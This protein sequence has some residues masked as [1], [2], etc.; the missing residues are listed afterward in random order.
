MQCKTLWEEKQK[1]TREKSTMALL[2]PKQEKTLK[3]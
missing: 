1:K 2:F 3:K